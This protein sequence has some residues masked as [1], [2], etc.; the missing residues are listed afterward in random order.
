[1]PRRVSRRDVLIIVVMLVTAAVAV[2][3]GVVM[4]T[5]LHG[6]QVTPSSADV[7]LAEMTVVRTRFAGQAPLVELD[8][9]QYR[10]GVHVNRPPPDAVRQTVRTLHGLAWD[11]A[12][13]RLVRLSLPLW[14]MHIG[15]PKNLLLGA[16]HLND[17]RI[18]VE[19]IERHGPGLIFDGRT[20]EGMPVLVW[21]E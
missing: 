21:A 20:P 10:G 4:Y 11:A 16:V 19:D 17:V 12:E 15:E 2:A 3:I 1:M 5:V 9:A 14:V 13:H 7:A 6:L 18:S 8:F